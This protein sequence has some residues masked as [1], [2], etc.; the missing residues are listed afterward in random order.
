MSPDNSYIRKRLRYFAL[1]KP[2]WPRILG[3]AK[4]VILDIGANDGGSSFMFHQVFPEAKLFSFEPDQRALERF[5]QRFMRHPRFAQHCHVFPYAVS[6]TDGKL[7]FHVSGGHNP[8]PSAASAC[9]GEWDLSG[10]IC[11]PKEHLKDNP[12]CTFDKTVE[13]DSL[14]LD[15]WSRE[16]EKGL[17]D[18]IWAD[19]QGAEGML[20]EGGRETL[21]RTRFFYTEY[22]NREVYEGQLDLKHILELLPDFEILAD[23][24][25]DVLLVNKKLS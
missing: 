21:S 25:S 15:T 7:T 5:K 17:I 19:V 13:V 2:N 18:L 12:W 11:S 4:P 20:I 16:V 23:Y 8:D 3:K 14:R 1:P 10:S 9:P 6:N 22:Y 24:G